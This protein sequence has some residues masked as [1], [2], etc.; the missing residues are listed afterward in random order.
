M[1]IRIHR[2]CLVPVASLALAATGCQAIGRFP[3]IEPTD[4]AHISYGCDFTQVYQFTPPQVETAALEAMAD[5]GFREMKREEKD[6]AV[7][8]R[9][10]TL[11]RRPA[12][13]TIRP[14]NK[15]AEMTVRIGLGDE[16]AS[17]ALIQRVALNFGTLP[18]VMIPLEPTHA[19]RNDPPPPPRPVYV[20][21]AEPIEPEPVEEV[22]PPLPPAGPS[23]FT[24][25]D[26]TP[27]KLKP[28]PWT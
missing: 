5:M 22:P 20:V 16:L 17:D 8:I 25:T 1:R 12:R 15:M 7:V 9:A 21:P 13:V 26:T 2:V 23:P 11:D 14:R 27:P 18:R 10:K 28:G 24:P 3:G 4:Y 19:R 6:D